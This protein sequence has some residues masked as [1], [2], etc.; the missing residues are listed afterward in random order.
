MELRFYEAPFFWVG[1]H[2]V[3]AP[4]VRS[5]ALRRNS[6]GGIPAKAGTTNTYSKIGDLSQRLPWPRLE[7]D[8]ADRDFVQKDFAD[9]SQFEFDLN[10]R[11]T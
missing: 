5:T 9:A 11:G 7:R 6:S 3:I 2:R 10:L 4:T 8:C 1:M